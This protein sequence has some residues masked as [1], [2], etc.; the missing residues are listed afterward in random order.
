MLLNNQ[1]KF[2]NKEGNN[3][4]P[5]VRPNLVV[6]IVDP[7]GSG[8]NAE[9]RAITTVDGK[10]EYVEI[11]NGG[12]NYSADTYFEF[13]D[14]TIQNN[15][16]T[17]ESNRVTITNGIITGYSVDL[18]D[19]NNNAFPYPASYVFDN[20][21]LPVVSAGLIESE[22]VFIVE[23]VIDQ[24][25][26]NVTHAYPSCDN[27]GPYNFSK[28]SATGTTG[29]GS[30]GLSATVTIPKFTS[31]NAVININQLDVINVSPSLAD[32]LS[33]GMT[34]SGV[35][36]DVD[37]FILDINP[38]LGKIALTKPIKVNGS[39]LTFNFHVPHYLKV[40]STVI[41]EGANFPGTHTV[42]NVTDFTFNFDCDTALAEVNVS[43][44]YYVKPK[45]EVR[46]K[47]GSDAE[48]FL[49][50]VTYN[51]DYP[52]ITKSQILDVEFL[53]PT[54][55]DFE[56]YENEWLRKL[57]ANQI[58]KRPLQIN[59]GV[60]SEV[61]G[62]YVGTIEIVDVTFTYS[63]QI[64]YSSI[65]EC[66]VEPEDERFGLLLENIGADINQEEELILRDSDINEDNT[67]YIL[68]N[69]KRKEMLLQAEQIWP[70]VGSY[71]GLVNII[72]W[73]GYY[74]I[75]IKEYFLN[76]N[77]E[78]VYYNK[79]RQVQIPFQLAEKGI[80]PESI[81]LVPSN[82]YRKTNLFGLFYDIVKDSG[83]YDE[84]GIPVTEDAFAFTNEEVLIKLF[85][86]KN[87]LKQ[88]F[89]P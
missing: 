82:Y 65:V 47:S 57:N 28:I 23:R 77:K 17:T 18:N 69:Q 52:T 1:F 86:L 27:Y 42:T 49:Y 6:S 31:N 22:N 11:L 33:I 83:E 36:V 66:E 44:E 68:L 8:A 3:I 34:V 2:F 59:Y 78:D 12:I 85:A 7:T 84:F 89:L 64:I 61:G 10:I 73:F 81:N 60:Q 40:G 38:V 14:L 45:F 79:Y 32:D 16:W 87:F 74:D 58:E 25:N 51:E 46:V 63:D 54:D 70:Y 39:G 5:D 48:W 53:A 13:I 72:N 75:R 26:G 56:L 76:V 15:V 88:K 67:N 30:N 19:L 24:T 21:F 43:G 20:Y 71:K 9:A 4:N 50:T 41:I 37:T 80:Q 29:P 55:P 62:V 35:G